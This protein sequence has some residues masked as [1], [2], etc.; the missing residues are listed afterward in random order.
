MERQDWESLELVAPLE[1]ATNLAYTLD[2]EVTLG[3]FFSLAEA[4]LGGGGLGAW[5]TLTNTSDY[6]LESIPMLVFAR[7]TSGRYIGMAIHGSAVASFT[8]DIGI[9]PGDTGTGVSVNDIEYF[10]GPMTYEVRAIGVIDVL[11]PTA[12]PAPV[13]TPVADWQGIPIM[14]GALNGGEADDGYRFSTRATIDEIAQFYEAALT[15]L[16]YSLATS[17]EERGIAYLLFERN[18]TTAIV[19]ISLS[20]EFNLVQITVAS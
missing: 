6:V 18:S 3:E 13:G 1:I 4:H 10:H 20:A 17:G 2:V 16:G 9:Q 12:E 14:P 11:P 19:G 7:D 5:T 8:E 15:E